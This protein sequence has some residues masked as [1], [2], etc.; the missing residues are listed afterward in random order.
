MTTE[1]IANRLISLCKDGQNA[2]AQVELY[3]DFIES[4]ECCDSKYK[5]MKGIKNVQSKT[6]KFFEFAEKIHSLTISDPLVTTDFFCFKLNVDV[7]LRRFGRIDFEE[8]CMYHVQ[9]GKIVKEEFY[10]SSNSVKEI[11]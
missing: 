3:D 4:I 8:L 11:L 9:D 1:Q 6:A 5:K 2:L 7:T 10:Y